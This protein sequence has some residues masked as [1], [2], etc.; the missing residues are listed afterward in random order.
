M[1]RPTRRAVLGSGAAA[2]G[3]LAGCL[4]SSYDDRPVGEGAA[5]WPADPTWEP[6]DGPPT[7]AEVREVTAVQ[8]L[9]IP[10]DLTFAAGDALLTERTGG[11][12]RFGAEAL[13]SDSELAPSDGELLIRDGELPDRTGPGE[14][15][16]LGVAAHPD[17][18]DTPV[19]FVYYTAD[20]DLR[21]R[22]VRYD[23]DADELTPVVDDIPA[24]EFH[25]GG[26]ITVGPD[27]HL[28]VC[29]GDAKEPANSQDA[30]NLGGAI[31]RVD[32]EGEAP[33]DTPD[34][35][36]GT[37]SRLYT[38]GHRN[39]QGI[40]FTP[41]GEPI[42]AEHGPQS[43]DEVSALRPGANY[44]WDV[45]RGGP[46]DTQY[47]AYGDYEEFTPP[48]LNTGELGTWAPSGIS[49]YKKEVI[50]AW[51]NRLFVAGL[52]SQTLFCVTLSADGASPEGGNRF[53][54]DWLDDRYTATVHKFYDGEYGRL[55]HVEVGPEGA[56]Y[57]LT[58]NRDG[59]TLQEFPKD[60]DDRVIRIEPQ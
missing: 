37:D 60:A 59:R 21:N 28:W 9:S 46:T 36:D 1:Q 53:D 11:L 34:F 50:P 23:I 29:T 4:S 32:L 17:Y 54:A 7:T 41:D 14:G 24:A 38:L 35:G 47:D 20:D 27:R 58:S 22:V 6:A 45:A 26:R 8:N 49:L 30:T 3:A 19:V 31:L 48:L 42:I 2:L 57:V 51:H 10:W 52:R 40:D 44:G 33:D 56:L 5:A 15:G 13:R 55:R 12:R 16:T 18:P 39:P 43:R 25:N